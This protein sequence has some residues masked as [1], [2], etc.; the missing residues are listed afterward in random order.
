MS[1]SSTTT[2]AF[3]LVGALG[4]VVLTGLISWVRT[5]GD[6]RHERTMKELEVQSATQTSRRAER[7]EAYGDFLEATNGMYQLAADLFARARKGDTLDFR[8]ETRDVIVSL[9]NHELTL[10]LVASAKVRR[11]AREYVESLRELLINATA[12][13][14]KDSTRESRNKLFTSMIGDINPGEEPTEAASVKVDQQSVPP[15]ATGI[16]AVTGDH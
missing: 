9:M 4:G 5:A 1:T 8:R 16:E 15:P 12:G 6:H 11:D 13:K 2:A 14:W 7:R 10:G 3:T